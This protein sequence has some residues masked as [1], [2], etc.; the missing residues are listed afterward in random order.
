MIS[1]D[2]IE[3]SPDLGDR[4]ADDKPDRDPTG[5]GGHEVDRGVEQREA[6]ADCGGDGDAVG[7]QRRGVVDQA[8]PSMIT[9]PRGTRS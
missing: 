6:A 4:G 9:T 8:R 1:T 7:D 3:L 5:H 2:V